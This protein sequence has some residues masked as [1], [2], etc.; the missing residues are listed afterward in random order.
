M[1]NPMIPNTASLSLTCVDNVSGRVQKVEPQQ[2]RVSHA[3]QRARRHFPTYY[4]ADICDGQAEG[5]MND[6]GM[7]TTFTLQL[8]RV[9]S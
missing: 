3:L 8:K 4:L 5:L 7:G 6:A 9:E 1:P 2:H